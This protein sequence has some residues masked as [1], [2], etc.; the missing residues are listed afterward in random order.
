MRYG[1]II[2]LAA[3]TALVCTRNRTEIKTE[4][5]TAAKFTPAEE[6][7][8]C[9]WREPERDMTLFFP[10]A[11]NHKQEARPLSGMRLDLQRILGRQ[12][13]AADQLLRV[14]WIEKNGEILGSIILKR[15]KGEHGA[16]E[17]VIA[18]SLDGTIRGVRAQ[19]CREPEQVAQ[20]FGPPGWI[21]AFSGKTATNRFALGD[22]LPMPS[23]GQESA[24]A[25]A[26]GVRL[27]LAVF[28]LAQGPKTDSLLH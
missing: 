4:P 27:S 3:V 20:N 11:T 22:D 24:R 14:N 19:R 23:E 8:V 2:L 13:S 28:A 18:Q 21:S 15:V 16:I 26:E 12:P 6:E 9:P 1:V 7:P 17:L 10:E 5:A 25:I